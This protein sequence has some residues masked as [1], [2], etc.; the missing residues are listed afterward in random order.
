MKHKL[1][2]LLGISFSLFSNA[3][4]IPNGGFEN[5]N[6]NS[7][8][9]P[10]N[11]WYTSN[12]D[13]ASLGLPYNALQ[14]TD[15][16]QGTYAVKMN[17][18]SNATDTM[19]GYILNG[20]P[21]TFTGGIP[22]TQHAATLSGFYKCNVMP[23]DTAFLL[24]IFK[25]GGTAISFDVQIFT[26]T[27]NSYT[28]FSLTL[29]VPAISSPDSII[30]GAVSS[31]AFSGNV[32]PGSMLQLDNLLFTG[33]TQQPTL[34]NGSFENWTG[35][36]RYVPQLWP[37]AGDSMLRTSDAHSG[38]Y[39]L[40]LKTVTYN[41]GVGASYATQGTMIQNVGITGGRPYSQINDTLCGW[42]KFVPNGIDSA[43]VWIQ[44]SAAHNAVGGAAAGLPPANAY[45][46]F[47]IPF[48]SI[49]TPDTLLVV[50]SSSFN[51]IN[52]A[53]GG[54]V[55]KIDDLYLKSSALAVPEIHWNDF[56]LVKLFPNP[57]NENCTVEFTNKENENVV[58]TVT[59]ETGRKV[60]EET[61]SGIGNHAVKIDT[62]VLAKGFYTVTLMQEERFTSRKLIVQ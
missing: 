40:Q 58:L 21:S 30:V 25:Q 52:Q 18:V 59:D 51:D 34:M 57:S 7:Y 20:D 22:Y 35:N 32:I 17:T 38:S 44:T 33:V 27:H 43:T 11:Y 24:C 3:Q 13:A 19:F 61:I 42:Y 26:G 39:A 37:T 9:S 28:P 29:N 4:T 54:S 48:T 10:Q 31:N 49:Q 46:F 47:S 15:P 45:T 62:S 50:F 12:P 60:S 1:L 16:Q 6:N 56:G 14:V 55:F 5:W 8:V 41:N 53:N 36:S 23:G 2:F